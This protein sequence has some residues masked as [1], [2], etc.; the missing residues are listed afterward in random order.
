M[1]EFQKQNNLQ[2]ATFARFETLRKH[3]DE[4]KP[5]KAPY[6]WYQTLGFSL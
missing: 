6:I 3:F 4:S 1:A 5:S 2:H